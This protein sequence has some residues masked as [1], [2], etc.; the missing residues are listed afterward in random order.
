MVSKVSRRHPENSG[1][2]AQQLAQESPILQYRNVSIA[3]LNHPHH[4]QN[5]R[6]G[7]T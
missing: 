7:L 4:L 1:H 3:K 5:A 2:P 6:L